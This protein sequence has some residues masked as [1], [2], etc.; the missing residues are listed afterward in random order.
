MGA[1]HQIVLELLPAIAQPWSE[2]PFIIIIIIII[3]SAL[4]GLSVL[5]FPCLSR[6]LE[7]CC[8]SDWP[9]VTGTTVLI[10]VLPALCYRYYSTNRG[11]HCPPALDP[12]DPEVRGGEG[13]P[14][15]PSCLVTRCTIWLT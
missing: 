5:C 6:R 10:E 4:T 2:W 11:T 3:A 9:S 13:T 12:I 8:W 7:V 14:W 15:E 1:Y